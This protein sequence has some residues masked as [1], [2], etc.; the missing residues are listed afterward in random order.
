M[1]KNVK[2]LVGEGKNA[3]EIAKT[4][5]IHRCTVYKYIGTTD[6]PKYKKRACST[7]INLLRDFVVRIEDLF[8]NNDKNQATDIY[9][10]I[11]EEGYAGSYRVVAKYLQ[12]LKAAKPSERF[13]EQIHEPGKQA[14]FDFKEKV[15]IPFSDGNR[16]VHLHFGTL[17]FSGYF[18]I[19]AYFYKNFEC[20][21]EGIHL[22]YES[23]GGITREI[24]FDNLS[25]CVN[26]V[27]EGKKRDYTAAFVRFLEHYGVEPSP[28]SPGKGSDKGD[29]EREI[30]T[31]AK[32]I[33]NLVINKGLVF[34]DL[35]DFN[36]WLKDY[37]EKR[38]PKDDR[39]AIEKQ[40]LKPLAKYD[41]DILCKIVYSKP[42]KHGTITIDGSAYSV[43]DSMISLDCKIV[44][45]Q[46]TVTIFP[47]ASA[48]CGKLSK[49]EHPRMPKGKNS[50]LL[51]HCIRSLS[52]KPQAMVCWA[53]RE[54]LFP[55]GGMREFYQQL[56]KQNSEF[57][58]KEFLQAVNLLQ[59]VPIEEIALG[60][61]LVLESKSTQLYADLKTLIMGH[62]T[63]SGNNHPTFTQ[64]ALQI[65]LAAFNNL[66]PG[67]GAHA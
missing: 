8:G 43:P 13:F 59:H 9:E 15:T 24:R 36:A 63:P 38:N 54:I 51:E 37:C 18:N 44:V 6:L 67:R 60:M 11:K 52:R 4:L 66:I 22:F 10:L 35:S 30:R 45:G 64:P 21:A 55:I 32:R 26:E 46:Q 40:K 7:R 50:I 17:P 28:C 20:Y 2:K 5:G 39:L 48:L 57:A 14:Q 34:K 23:I 53:H 41:E 3:V 19:H 12:H 49:I 33:E 42:T 1:F 58:E 56:K 27:L 16:I 31:Q 65:D 61:Q 47:R 62:R 29:V 25:P